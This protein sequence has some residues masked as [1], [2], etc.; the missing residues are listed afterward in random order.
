MARAVHSG[1]LCRWRDEIGFSGI[2]AMIVV[3]MRLDRRKS[4]ANRAFQQS[5]S[6]AIG[7]S[8]QSPLLQ[9]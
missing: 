3:I 2:D 6:V 1:Q 8:V 7:K 4:S 9:S 5:R